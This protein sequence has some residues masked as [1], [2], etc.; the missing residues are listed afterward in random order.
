MI[1]MQ[2][3]K[4]V[5]HCAGFVGSVYYDCPFKV[6]P[7]GLYCSTSLHMVM[8]GRVHNTANLPSVLDLLCYLARDVWPGL[9]VTRSTPQV[10][11]VYA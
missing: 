10:L 3:C 4:K 7:L 6:R 9:Y 1:M 5:G 11:A 8:V 2:V